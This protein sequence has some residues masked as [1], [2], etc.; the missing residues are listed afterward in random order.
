[1]TIARLSP[2]FRAALQNG[3]L[4]LVAAYLADD[5][6]VN[7]R[8][9]RGRTPLMLAASRGHAEICR[10]LLEN[11]ANIS[12]TNDTGHTALE[13]ARNEGILEVVKVIESYLVQSTQCV[14]LEALNE[15]VPGQIDEWQ[16]EN[17]VEAPIENAQI[18]A[19]I[20]A[21]QEVVPT[22]RPVDRDADWA[23]LISDLPDV[24][25]LEIGRKVERN[26]IQTLLRILI[27]E[28]RESGAFRPSL[29]ATVAVELDDT[30][31]GDIFKNIVQMLNENGWISE[32]NEDDWYGRGYSIYS[33]TDSDDEYRACLEYLIDLLSPIN[34]P[35][36]HLQKE[37]QRSVLL[38]R[39]GEE[40]IGRSISARLYDAC[41][42]LAADDCVLS[43]LVSLRDKVEG[44]TYLV[45]RISRVAADSADYEDAGSGHDGP[46]SPGLAGYAGDLSRFSSRLD[47]AIAAY[48]DTTQ[49]GR[50][51]RIVQAVKKL[52]LTGV[53][54][55]AIQKELA[56]AGTPNQSLGDAL[57]HVARL[58]SEMFFANVRL[59]ISVAEK[60]RWSKLRQMDRIQEAYIGLLKAI[61]KFDFE[62]GI[63]FSTYATWWLRQAVTRA[64]ANDGHTI[65]L[66]VHMLERV[67]K[68]NSVARAAGFDTA[69]E[70][71]ISKL[72]SL[73]DFS[74]SEV[75]KILS[76]VEEPVLWEE[77]PEVLTAALAVTDDGDSPLLFSERLDLERVVRECLD[78]LPSREAEII[79]HRF[80]LGEAEE[81]T[82]EEIGGL[83]NLTRERIRQLETKALRKL[84]NKSRLSAVLNS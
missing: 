41:I 69:R 71:K 80:G 38:D 14:S 51:R 59:A 17:E 56:A 24:I 33:E 68:L 11:G 67:N 19:T 12:E 46:E 63:K 83:F 15:V 34:D 60:Y 9:Q 2:L 77:S 23:D 43:V 57:N 22:G 27:S 47:E 26:E 16:P 72:S 81:K 31:G 79:K 64:I 40:R 39:E 32:E 62:R 36:F 66:P 49:K 84:R 52:E 8:D 3:N 54:F 82:L 61:D 18:R 13:I 4:A 55:R 28:A 6:Q 10:L 25:D 53:G 65:R 7:A 30:A 29:V 1:M 5:G 70:M 76:V 74:E 45:S 78:E 73:T 44:S 48:R 37:V 50:I 58:E 42:A 21:S 35:F 20:I 75:R